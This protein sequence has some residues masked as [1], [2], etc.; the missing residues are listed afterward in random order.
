M[1]FGHDC[2]KYTDLTSVLNSQNVPIYFCRRIPGQQQFAYRFLEYNPFDLKRAYPFSTDRTITA[3]AGL[4]Y[5]YSLSHVEKGS[6]TNGKWSNYTYSNGTFNGSILLPVQVDT[7]DGTIYT[8]RGFKRPS[9]ATVIACGQRCIWMWAHK[10]V[11][12]SDAS[13]FYQCPVTVDP[14]RSMRGNILRDVHIVPD[15]I[16]RLAASSIGLQGGNSDPENGWIQSQ[17]YPI[18]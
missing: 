8:Y 3:S 16:A 13:I 12:D 7:F 15:D 17:F 18:G 5:N 10:T 11:S 4:C 2:E 9:E 14:V 1:T 6:V